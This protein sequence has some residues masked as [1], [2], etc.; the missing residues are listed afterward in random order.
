MVE[1][2]SE[3]T[4]IAFGITGSG[5][6]YTLNLLAGIDPADSEDEDNIIFKT[7]A[8]ESVTKYPSCS[9]VRLN[10]KIKDRVNLVDVPGMCDTE[11]GSNDLKAVKNL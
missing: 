8:G 6:S 1:S 4:V 2:T 5:K 7:A 3:K 10:S 9:M 11:G